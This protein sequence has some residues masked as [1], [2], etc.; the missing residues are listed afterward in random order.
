MM[1]IHL[2]TKRLDIQRYTEE[3]LEQ[4]LPLFMDDNVLYYYLPNQ[5]PIHSTDKLGMYLSD[6]DDGETSFLFSCYKDMDLIAIFSLEQ[7]SLENRHAEC[8]IALV[9]SKYYGKGY[10]SEIINE[11]LLYLF[12]K[13]ELNR[14]FIR[15]IAGN[16][17]SYHLFSKLGFKHEGCLRQHVKRNDKYLDMHFMGILKTEFEEFNSHRKRDA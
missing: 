11:F 8:G 3:D 17:R 10:A 4:V 16:E 9:K 13:I 14:I 2:K 15:Y 7:F 5:V 12:E 6:W 1:N